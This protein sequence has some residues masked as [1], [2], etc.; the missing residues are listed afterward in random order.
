M[1]KEI[2]KKEGLKKIH[3]W[4]IINFI[5]LLISVFLFV[6]IYKMIQKSRQGLVVNNIGE[7]A[8][9]IENNNNQGKKRRFIDG[10][11]QNEGSENLY[12]VSFMIDNHVAA[13]PSSGLSKANLIYEAEVEGG[14]TR[15]MA[16]YANADD[17]EKIGPVRS[18]RPYFIDW[19]HEFSGVY[20]HC[21][22]SPEALVK[23]AKDGIIDFNEFYNGDYFWRD[24]NRSAPHNVYISSEKIGEYLNKK[25]LDSGN[26]LSWKF[27]DESE[28]NERPDNQ[29]ITIGYAGDDFKVEWVYEKSGNVYA[30]NMGGEAH[31]EESGEVIKVKNVIIQYI[32]ANEVDEKLRLKMEVVGEGEAMTCFD[33]TCKKGKWEKKNAA[34]RTRFYNENGEEIVF[35]AG[36]TWI[37]IVRPEREVVID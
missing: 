31:K 7:S 26:F 4:L 5:F 30:R 10:V 19:N 9:N 16:I 17:V 6:Y 1:E 14:I 35:N 25:G 18:A 27:K 3:F 34:A 20:G 2:S 15:F 24:G 36:A 8:V 13:R 11:Y 28:D 23:I 22:G 21:G 29:R 32:T 12:P 37:S 33:G